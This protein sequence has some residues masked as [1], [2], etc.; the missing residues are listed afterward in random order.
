[1]LDNSELTFEF[2]EGVRYGDSYFESRDASEV[3]LITYYL[4]DDRRN[5]YS[6]S[7][8]KS[9]S[10]AW[11]DG[12]FRRISIQNLSSLIGGVTKDYPIWRAAKALRGKL[13][14]FDWLSEI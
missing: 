10:E 12:D 9:Y 1:M 5:A 7:A 2:V 6:L 14:L 13:Y 3:Y 4:V 8:D 11:N